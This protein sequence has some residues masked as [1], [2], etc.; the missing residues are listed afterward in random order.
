MTVE[1]WVCGN[2]R[3]GVGTWARHVYVNVYVSVVFDL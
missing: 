3:S 1:P 2:G